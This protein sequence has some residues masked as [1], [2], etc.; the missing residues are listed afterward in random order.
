MNISVN[1]G[2]HKLQQK[3]IPKKHRNAILTPLVLIG[4]E[5]HRFSEH[6][7]YSASVPSNIELNS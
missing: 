4:A 2:F 5:L 3:S 1:V 7:Q 6:R